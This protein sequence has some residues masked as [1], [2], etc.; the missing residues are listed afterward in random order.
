MKRQL[1]LISILFSVISCNSIQ[2]QTVHP[3]SVDQ[4]DSLVFEGVTDAKAA[5]DWAKDNCCTPE[6]KKTLSESARPFINEASKIFNITKAAG[7]TYHD[8]KGLNKD[9]LLADF[10][11]L[12][13]AISKLPKKAN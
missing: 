11:K 5:I 7:K 2:N 8:T 12:T 13:S 9:E 10:I 6:P 1:F 3:G 4:V